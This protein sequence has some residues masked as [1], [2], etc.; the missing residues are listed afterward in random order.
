MNLLPALPCP[1]LRQVV[2]HTPAPPWRRVRGFTLI[3]LLV[4]LAIVGIL[5]AIAYPS[6]TAHV[7]Q[8]RRAVAQGCLSE[9][10]Q[11]MERRYTTQFSYA[12]S[13]LPVLGCRTDLSAAYTFQF[14]SNQ[15]TA[16]TF[17]IQAVPV[18][19][20]PQAT[21]RCATLNLTHTGARSSSSTRTD[22]WR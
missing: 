21:D 14:A 17:T 15:P 6:Y 16:S 7:Q 12:G 20:G 13:T 5:A 18:T 9:L 4:V 22:C 10:A 11:A 3:E 2:R 1:D 8:G 19:P